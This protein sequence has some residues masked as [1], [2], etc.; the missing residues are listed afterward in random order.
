MDHF[1]HCILILPVV[2]IQEKAILFLKFF[3]F[4]NQLHVCFDTDSSSSEALLPDLRF[5]SPSSP[6]RSEVP[7]A[8]SSHS[9]AGFHS[10][11]SILLIL[12][13]G[14][15]ALFHRSLVSCILSTRA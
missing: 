12:L 13:L 3:F 14:C 1:N 5:P 9:K 15:L 10:E 4:F 6:P 7:R 2:K 11:V 8:K